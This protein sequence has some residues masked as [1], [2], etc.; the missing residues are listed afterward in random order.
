MNKILSPAAR[1][2]LSSEE[3]KMR[4][5]LDI[6][7]SYM[8]FT[9]WIRTNH[10]NMTRDQSKEVI[11]KYTEIPVEDLFISEDTKAVLDTI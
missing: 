8:T 7:I 10:K 11:S 3:T 4:I 2:K 6:G 5:C 9:R 1:E